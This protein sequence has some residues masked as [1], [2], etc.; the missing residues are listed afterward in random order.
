MDYVDAYIGSNNVEAGY[1]CGED[2]I[3]RC[4]EGGKVAILDAPLDP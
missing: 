2:L 1:V 3:E 4:P